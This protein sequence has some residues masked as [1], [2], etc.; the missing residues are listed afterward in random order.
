MSLRFLPVAAACALSGALCA[1]LTLGVGCFDTEYISVER[2]PVLRPVG[3]AC[4]V[5]VECAT[6]RCVAGVCDDGGCNNDDDCRNDEL[7]VFGACEPADEFAC[8]PDQ[9]PLLSRSPSGSIEFGEVNVGTTATQTV[10]ITNLGD[11]L[12]TLSAA[13]LL[14]TGSPDFSCDRCDPTNYPQRIPPN[15]TFDIIVA[16]SPTGAG[17]ATSQLLVNSDDLTAEDDGRISI[18][19]H[20]SYSGQPTIVVEPL[21]VNFDYVAVGS[22]RTID[23]QITNRGTGNAA[24]TITDLFVESSTQFTIPDESNINQTNPKLLGHYNPDLPDTILTVPVTFAP[25]GTP[26]NHTANL[27]IR[28]SD[29]TTLQVPLSGSSLGPPQITVSATELEY[30]CQGSPLDPCPAPEAYPVG[31]VA[32]RQFTITNSGQSNLTINM[33]L[34]GEAGDFAVSPSFVPP[35]AP[36]GMMPITVFFN[37]SAPSDPAN[38]FDPVEAFDAMLNI[39]SNDTD[40]G[41]DVLKTVVLRGFSKGGQNDQVL[42]LEMNFENADNSWA[43]NDYRDVDLELVSPTGF[44]CAKPIRTWGESPPGSGNYVVI[45]EED[46]CDEW[47]AYGQEGQTNWIALGQYEEPERIIVFGLGPTGAEGGVFRANVYYI[48]D[49]ANIPTGLLANI[50][51]I[52]GSILLGILG[53]AVGIPITVP[54]DQISDMIANNCFDHESSTATLHISRDGVEDAA[55]QVRLNNKG[56]VREI[57]TLTRSNGQFCNENLGVLCQ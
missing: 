13:G 8:Q 23:V 43:G 27:V 48:E 53:G 10:T 7:C 24:L 56:E 29:F 41:T 20:A 9:A 50:L 54:P 44:S 22:N 2:D 6:G 11:C 49:C 32:Y 16:F 3:D 34:G 35:I 42:K 37:P 30:K 38:R 28:T 47:N 17:D 36:G 4:T 57:A 51:G 12:L 52:G 55:P 39:T 1:T 26:A 21:E 19:L 31:M 45:S 15:R 40:P 5:D 14:S 18:D 46:L 25:Q 33:T